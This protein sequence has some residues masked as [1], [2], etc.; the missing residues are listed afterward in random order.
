[1]TTSSPRPVAIP[2][3]TALS[4]QTDTRYSSSGFWA[5]V[6]FVI[7]DEGW[8]S[9]G[10]DELWIHVEHRTPDL[11]LPDL[12]LSIIA[13][14]PRTPPEDLIAAIT[15][16]EHLAVVQ[17]PQPTTVAGHAAIRVD[18]VASTPPRPFPQ[19]CPGFAEL[20]GGGTRFSASG[21]GV[22]LLTSP[23]PALPP[24]S[25]AFGIAYCRVARIWAVDA[26]GSTI[27]IIAAPTEP[28]RFDDL[29]VLADALVAGIE[30]GE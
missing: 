27:T 26:H 23:N 29:I 7:A 9:L 16:R 13:N 2:T 3:G 20:G 15:T 5:P 17:G 22:V 28:D 30:F 11:T 4:W 14:A 18:L 24:A 10:W 21:L 6:E 8:W 12:D 25:W 1:M 19:E